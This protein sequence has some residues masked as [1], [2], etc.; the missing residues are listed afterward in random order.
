MELFLNLAW[1]AVAAVLVCL[2]LRS[3]APTVPDRRRQLITIAVLIAM[4]FPVISMSDD[5]LAVQ[6]AFEADNYVRRVHLVAS[7]TSIQPALPVLMTALWA[8]LGFPF[9][10]FISPSALPVEE[11]PH[12]E[13]A[14][15]GNRPPP[16]A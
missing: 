1:L 9:L 4:L 8:G 6:N 11:P 14:R 7:N 2:C 13:L 10:R 16:A 3:E 5:L 15:F 12:P